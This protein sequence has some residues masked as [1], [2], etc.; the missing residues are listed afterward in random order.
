MYIYFLIFFLLAWFSLVKSEKIK[1]LLFGSSGLLLFFLAAFR[2][3]GI[4]KDYLGYIEY[5]D[6]VLTHSFSVVEPSFIL[7]T[8]AIDLLNGNYLHLFIIYALFGVFLKFYAIHKLTQ[9]KLLSVLIYFCSFF[10]LL[11][12][13]QIRAGV[14][15]GLLLLC[16]DPL[17]ERKFGQ[18][19]V[20][21]SLAFFFHYSAIVI[22][23]LYLLKVNNIN[24]S[25]YTILIPLSYLIYF[26]KFDVFFFTNY[27]PIPL[28]QSKLESYKYYTS[29]NS[30][31]NVF[32]FVHISRCL[33]AYFFL[34]KCNFFAETNKYSIILTKIYFIA[35]FIYLAFA[36]IP[37]I[38]SRVSELMIVV[39][40]I[41]IPFL[42]LT[43]K[44]KYL[45]TLIVMGIG[46]AFLS[47][48]LFYTKLLTF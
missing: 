21:A 22:F 35:I 38:S 40:I 2:K 29:L 12:M 10:L 11:E 39:E 41:L 43:L 23:P 8:N 30:T 20:F 44:P 28:I 16:I 9:F 6:N 31:I 27:I 17:K 36:Q 15:A 46:L 47:F 1:F 48:S 4:D 37:A 18:F 3:R 24:K 26:L 19:M 7:I 33:L 45:S 34:W 14:A 25:Y 32:N 13:T 5:F 42:T